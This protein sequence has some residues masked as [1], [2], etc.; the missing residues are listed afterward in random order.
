MT[1]EILTGAVLII[2]ALGIGYIALTPANE[3]K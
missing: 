3:N 2:L 1:I